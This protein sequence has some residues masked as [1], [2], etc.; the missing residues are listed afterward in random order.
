MQ[1]HSFTE[2]T[3]DTL[4][5]G[6]CNLRRSLS[7][8]RR[9]KKTFSPGS[10]P[11]SPTHIPH[12]PLRAVKSNPP[13]Y[14]FSRA[15]IASSP[16]SDLAAR[17][18]VF[19]RRHYGSVELLNST[20]SD[21]SLN[22]GR[23]RLETGERCQE[24]PVSPLN[25]PVH[26]ENP[27]F[28]TRWYF[29][30]FL[31]KLHQNYVGIDLDKDVF[32]L[33]VVVTDANNHNVPQYR[34]I[35][36]TK[37]GA[38]KISLSY[39]PSKPQTV[40]GIL[41][42][43][44]MDRIEKGPK[45]IFNPEIQKE[46]LVLEEQEGSVNFKI[47]VLYAKEGQTSDDEFFCNEHGS[48]EFNKFLR[49]LGD[50]VRLKGWDKFKAGLDVKSNTTGEETIYT[51]YEGHEIMFHVS[52]MLPFSSEN[53]QQVERKRHIGNDIVN[54]IFWDGDP[55]S[56][57]SFKPSMM[58]T[59]F[60]HIFALVTYNPETLRYRLNVFSQ[61]SVPLFGP[62]L[63][64]PPEFFDADEFRDFLLVKLINGEKAAVNNPVFTQKRERTLEMLIKNLYLDYMP[65]NNMLNRRA[66]SDVIQ[67][68]NTSRRK[69]DARRAEFVRIG[70]TLKLKT[71]LKGNAPTSMVSTGM[72]KTQP[73][74][75]QH[76][77]SDFC[78]PII[79][80]DSW[81]DKLVL[82]TDQG[83]FVLEDGLQPRMIFD[84]S[85]GVKQIN[86]V[87]A[88]G[89]LIMRK[90]KGKDGKIYAFRLLDFEG[91]AAENIIRSKVDC[92][93]HKIEKTKGCHLYA[94]SRPGSSHLR[95]V[96][97]VGRRLLVFT[98]KHSAEW[99]VW[100]CPSM[101]LDTVEGF[102]FVRELECFDTPQIIS[103]VDGTKGENDG[104]RIDNQICVGYKHQ[105]D[106]INEKNGDTLQLFQTDS[107]K[108]VSLVSAIDIYED[109]EAELLL[110]YNYVSHF[111]KLKEENSNDFDIHW[112]SE[113][114]HIVCAFP[115]VMAFTADTIEIR[116]IVNGNLVHT[117]TMPDLTL[118]SSKCD[119]Y[120]ATSA[121]PPPPD[122]RQLTDQE[123]CSTPPRS[124]NFRLSP[125]PNSKFHFSST[126]FIYK[127]PI[128]CLTGHVLPEK[129]VSSQSSV[130]QSTLLAPVM[131]SA[132]TS[133]GL[134]R[135]SPLLRSRNLQVA[136]AE[137]GLENN[138]R[139]DSSSSDSGITMLRTNE[140]S[141][142]ESPSLASGG[143]GGGGA[144]FHESD[145]V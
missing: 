31:G 68:A 120:F 136:Q 30:Y 14:S 127:I 57:P 97:A 25:S 102:T 99:L 92:R 114:F 142:P 65:E 54:I 9:K 126:R 133:P 36:W 2:S 61:E 19:S 66:F 88:H 82:A 12:R 48:D 8:I 1:R 103:L 51:V 55:N 64:S 110:S 67:D 85:V 16:A 3:L 121:Y 124:P 137:Q 76:C 96:V 4:S 138:E 21:P 32:L 28:Q 24:E 115:Y 46:I 74:E 145:I 104:I 84:K 20:D 106:L 63:P 77:F 29:K 113:P 101:E 41:N 125:S 15:D 116:L 6:I 53:K 52:T 134:L 111:Q 45:E 5:E 43:L 69:E 107:N 60:T 130:Q 13:T 100:C 59:R 141:P 98:W 123:S 35:L 10:G 105:F 7:S 34:A 119:I 62:P 22:A 143:V 81:G 87:E 129:S 93:D 39:N 79:T 56:A 78:H 80:S 109:E 94:L 135:R 58:K 83:T 26:L 132:G 90:D 71:I 140:F 95:M 139:H 118:I 44:D 89:L 131:G 73:W 40:K 108:N 72:L 70:Q 27:E 144:V 122:D 112:N 86:V 117:M 33:S 42:H 17:R 50:R 49:L 128:S 91:E 75:P 47:G 38:K 37:T 18:G 23:F 11:A